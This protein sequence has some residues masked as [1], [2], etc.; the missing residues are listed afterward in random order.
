MSSGS[1]KMKVRA[2]ARPRRR[3]V[4]AGWN[5]DRQWSGRASAASTAASVGP[6]SASSGGV[7]PASQRLRMCGTHNQA[8]ICARRWVCLCVC[9]GALEDNVSASLASMEPARMASGTSCCSRSPSCTMMPSSCVEM[10]SRSSGQ[11]RRKSAAALPSLRWTA[12]ARW[13]VLCASTRPD[14]GRAASAALR[15]DAAALRMACF[16]R[17]HRSQGARDNVPSWSRRCVTSVLNRG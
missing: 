15:V 6:A 13:M 10:M 2:N 11:R 17:L 1:S 5:A 7:T 8:A 9:L 3:F 12:R 16:V 4:A 14:L